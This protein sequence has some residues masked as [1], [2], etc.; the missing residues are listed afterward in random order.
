MIKLLKKRSR[1]DRKSAT[2]RKGVSIDISRAL[3]GFAAANDT[4]ASKPVAS[5]PSGTTLR[6]QAARPIEIETVEDIG[7]D[8][9]EK[10]EAWLHRDLSHL[11][12]GWSALQKNQTDQNRFNQFQLANHN[13]K[14]MAA[15]YGYPAISRLAGSLDRLLKSGIWQCNEKLVEL[16]INACRAVANSAPTTKDNIDGLSKAVCDALEA[17]VNHLTA[18]RRVAF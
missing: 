11:T 3:P 4:Q 16:H 5:E 7:L 1:R 17:Q 13:L 2:A 9:E 8:Q 18:T 15:T 12:N 6:S 14:G 10:Y